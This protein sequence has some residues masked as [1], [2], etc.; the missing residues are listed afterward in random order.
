MRGSS[1]WIGV[2]A[3][4][5]LT[6][7]AAAAPPACVF[8]DPPRVIAQSGDPHAHGSRLL[9]VWEVADA[10]VWWSQQAGPAGYAAFRAQ[11]AAKAGPTD[12]ALLLAQTPWTNN[13]LVAANAAQWVRPANCL[14]MLLQQTQNRRIA[15]FDAPT[16]FMAVIL[17]SS[18]TKRL[19]VYFYTTNQ[20]GIGRATPVSDLAAEDH[21]AGWTVLAALHNHAFH[22]GQP[23]LNAPLAPSKPDAQFNA[24]YAAR[25]GLAEAWITNGLHTAHIPAAAFDKFE[26]DGE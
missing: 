24:N 10:P 12:P 15:P 21:R 6:S 13:R 11:V 17:R 20:D 4:L 14:E 9:Q 18:D 22:P 2:I 8:P 26:R 23:D 25:V 5:V 1:C 7:A 19:R 3:A 16:E